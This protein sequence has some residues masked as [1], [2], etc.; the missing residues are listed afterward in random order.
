MKT[1]PME[2]K[3]LF[4]LQN[5]NYGCWCPGDTRG[6]G[7]SSHGIARRVNHP[8]DLAQA[9]CIQLYDLQYNTICIH[10]SNIK[11]GNMGQIL[12]SSKTPVAPFT[13][14]DK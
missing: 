13:N 1:F 9:M 10:C 14:M 5:Q 11:S 3:D 7:I 12:D 2:D 6:Q 8:R 4:I